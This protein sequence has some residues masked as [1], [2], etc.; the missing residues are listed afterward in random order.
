M[1]AQAGDILLI[2][3]HH[4][5]EADQKALVLQVRGEHGEPPFIV[6]WSDGH[7]GM[8]FPGSDA[9]IQH[10]RRPAKQKVGLGK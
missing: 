6:R 4:I 3:S 10:R 7:E 5:G 2:R 1:H 8:I 9:V